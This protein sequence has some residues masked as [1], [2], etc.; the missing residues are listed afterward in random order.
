MFKSRCTIWECHR[1]L[2]ALPQIEIQILKYE[3]THTQKQEIPAR[4]T[5][6][7]AGGEYNALTNTIFQQPLLEALSPWRCVLANLRVGTCVQFRRPVCS[8]PSTSEGKIPPSNLYE[9]LKTNR[10]Y[11]FPSFFL[12][13]CRKNAI[14]FFPAKDWATLL[15][16]FDFKLNRTCEYSSLDRRFEI[17]RRERVT[18]FEDYFAVLRT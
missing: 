1:S 18:K 12:Y 13:S 11:D 10:L 16:N 7:D 5:Q 6:P 14:H 3:Q 15:S 9:C 8:T 4:V 17:T 2:I